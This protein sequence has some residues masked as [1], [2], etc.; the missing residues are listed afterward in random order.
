MTNIA[1]R[2]QDEIL[3][4]AGAKAKVLRVPRS[5]YIRRAIIAMNEKVDAE[6]KRERMMKA[7]RLVR[8]ESMEVNVEF[9]AIEDVPD[10]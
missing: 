6:L 2:V 4:E 9:T 1:V 8:K 7:S 3:A 10:A 5:E